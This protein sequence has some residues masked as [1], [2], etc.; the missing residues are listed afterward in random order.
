[1]YRLV[2][3]KKLIEP[4]DDGERGP[5]LASRNRRRIQGISPHE[6]YAGAEVDTTTGWPNAAGPLEVSSSVP[7]S[8][9]VSG[10]VCLALVPNVH[11]ASVNGRHN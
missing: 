8:V 3:I 7:G 11:G 10:A 6:R 4:R 9:E 2:G 1:M 5:R